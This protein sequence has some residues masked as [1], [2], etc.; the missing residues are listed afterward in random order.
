MF[1]ELYFVL[2]HDD[3]KVTK[4]VSLSL[5]S[6]EY[7]RL[8]VW[9][10]NS[11]AQRTGRGSLDDTLG[12]EPKIQSIVLDLLEDLS[13]ALTQGKSWSTSVIYTS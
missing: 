1:R 6:D 4:Q 11:G 10:E 7:G 5:L 13:A 8:G 12:S 9:G 3:C 2:A